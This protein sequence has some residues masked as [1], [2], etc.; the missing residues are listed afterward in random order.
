MKDGLGS[1][2]LVSDGNAPKTRFIN[3][4][5]MSS[6]QHYL[7]KKIMIEYSKGREI[8]VWSNEGNE[9]YPYAPQLCTVRATGTLSRFA[10]PDVPTHSVVYACRDL[11]TRVVNWPHTNKF[12]ST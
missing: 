11:R 8:I 1:A 10:E 5:L 12:T 9:Y 4:H 3:G 6:R 2:S 7:S